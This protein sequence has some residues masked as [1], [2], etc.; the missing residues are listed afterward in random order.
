MFSEETKELLKKAEQKLN[1]N[2]GIDWI[3]DVISYLMKAVREL[4]DR[5]EKIEKYQA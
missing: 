3:S 5:L 4:D 2:Q 1:D